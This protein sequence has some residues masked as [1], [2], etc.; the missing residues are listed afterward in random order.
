MARCLPPLHRVLAQK[1]AKFNPPKTN[2]KYVELGKVDT[3]YA[4][5]MNHLSNRIFGY[6]R[7]PTPTASLKIIDQFQCEPLYKQNSVVNYYP[8]H[9]EVG[10][11]IIHLRQY[12]LFRDEHGDFHEER[13][14]LKVLRGKAPPPRKT[15]EEGRRYKQKQAKLADQAAEIAKL[16]S[17]RI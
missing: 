6:L 5:N 13:K 2:A 9:I 17:V 16:G 15:K 11:L 7:R 12:G 14:R 8:R 10:Q 3:N 1:A 4:K